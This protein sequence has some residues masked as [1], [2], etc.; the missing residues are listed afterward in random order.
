MELFGSSLRTAQAILTTPLFR[1]FYA[2]GSGV[3]ATLVGSSEC[4]PARAFGSF[5][6]TCQ[7]SLFTAYYHTTK[8]GPFIQKKFVEGENNALAKN[9][10]SILC[11]DL[12]GRESTRFF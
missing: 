11:S 6:Q 1:R 9:P 12:G 3:A 10:P 4:S 7:R 5:F 2:K 8:I